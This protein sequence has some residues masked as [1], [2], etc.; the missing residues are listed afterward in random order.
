MPILTPVLSHTRLKQQR[1]VNT[2]IATRGPDRM[3]RVKGIP[4]ASTTQF[5][6]RT[7]EPFDVQR[8]MYERR[9]EL[10]KIASDTGNPNVLKHMDFHTMNRVGRMSK[11]PIVGLGMGFGITPPKSYPNNPTFSFN[12][13]LAPLDRPQFS[14]HVAAEQS[15]SLRTHQLSTIQTSGHATQH[16]N[17]TSKQFS[18]NTPN[19]S[20][21]HSERF[22]RG[23]NGKI[24]VLQVP[25][26]PYINGV[27][28]A[29]RRGGGANAKST[30][31]GKPPHPMLPGPLKTFETTKLDHASMGIARNGTRHTRRDRLGRTSDQRLLGQ[32]DMRKDHM[33]NPVTMKLMLNHNIERDGRK[34]ITL[35][36]RTSKIANSR[37]RQAQ[38]S[39]VVHPNLA[40]LEQKM[41][42]AVAGR[43]SFRGKRP[44]SAAHDQE[45]MDVLTHR[46]LDQ[47]SDRVLR[48]AAKRA[49]HIGGKR[50][51][52]LPPTEAEE[53]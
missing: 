25:R 28:P 40:N 42:T 23:V 26:A 49:R 10:Q 14:D 37:H 13:S 46:P 7:V 9:R 44:L 12:K 24:P 31:I 33:R 8:L 19:K 29:S 43:S 47:R 34:P 5:S 4:M 1:P 11:N 16:G 18:T 38:S 3:R 6:V 36:S 15:R 52:M 39:G 35:D 27:V 17:M 32:T 50:A 2:G 20:M 21:T 45:P 22:A 53:E 30:P 48:M 41:L 51:G